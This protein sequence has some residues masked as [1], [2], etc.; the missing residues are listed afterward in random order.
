MGDWRQRQHFLGRLPG[1]ITKERGTEAEKGGERYVRH[2]VTCT[3]IDFTLRDLPLSLFPKHSLPLSHYSLTGLWRL[4]THTHT[5]MRA[6]THTRTP[7]SLIDPL[8]KPTQMGSG[9]VHMANQTDRECTDGHTL[10]LFHTHTNTHQINFGG[11]FLTHH[12]LFWVSTLHIN[13]HKYMTSQTVHNTYT[14]IFKCMR[15]V[16]GEVARVLLCGCFG[17]LDSL[18]S[19]V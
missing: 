7:F 4:C 18:N 5:H 13:T 9:P 8:D 2:E 6:H 3:G 1:L 15:G 10:S 14:D 16:F 17:V 19:K 12:P 11:Y